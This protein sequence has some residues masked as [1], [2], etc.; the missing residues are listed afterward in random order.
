M[1]HSSRSTSS[2]KEDSSASWRA[3][4]SLETNSSAERAREA[5][6]TCA[7]TEVPDR[8]N[9]LPKMRTSSRVLGNLTNNRIEAA[10]NAFVLPRKSSGSLPWFISGFYFLFFRA[11]FVPVDSRAAVRLAR[12]LISE[13][14]F[15]A[16][17]DGSGGRG[18]S[19]L[20]T[21]RL[22]TADFGLLS[23]EWGLPSPVN[24]PR[25]ER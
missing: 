9:C 3:P 1:P 11:H 5:S 23:T 18:W 16:V 22:R 14:L 19:F 8:S 13:P 7:A 21:Y 15:F 10:A 25:D 17:T 12:D 2:H 24:G 4:P 6:R 20:R